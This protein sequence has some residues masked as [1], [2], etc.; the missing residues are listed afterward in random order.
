MKFPTAIT[1]HTTSGTL[2]LTWQDG[3]TTCL[4]HS[5]LRRRCRCAA[6]EQDRRHHGRSPEAADTIRI[7]D[8]R[9]IGDKGLN[10]V[11]SDGHGRGIYPWDYLHELGREH[12]GSRETDVPGAIASSGAIAH[13]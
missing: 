3:S 4:P 2:E 5:L 10:L 8:V 1:S 12:S 7:A 13:A 11:F 9:P 6:C